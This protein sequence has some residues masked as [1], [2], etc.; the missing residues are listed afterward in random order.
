MMFPTMKSIALLLLTLVM[1]ATGQTEPAEWQNP[2]V[3]RINKEAPRATSVPFPERAQAMAGQP[4][5]WF[6]TLNHQ[7]ERR[8]MVPVSKTSGDYHGP[9]KFHYAG[10]PAARPAD[11]YKPE[12][13]VSSWPSIPVPSN[14]QIHGFGVPLYTNVAYPFKKDPP[15]V[16]STPPGFFTNFPEAQRNPVGSY[17]RSFTLPP[18]WKGRHTFIAFNGVDSAFF[19][20]INGHKV[21][22]SQDSRTTAE[23]DISAFVQPG[24]NIVAVEVYQLSDGSYLEDQDMWRLSGIFRDVYLWSAGKLQVR[25]FWIKAGLSDDY[26]SGTLEIEATLRELSGHSGPATLGFELLDPSGKTIAASS[27]SIS[28]FSKPITLKA[29]AIPNVAAWSAEIPTLYTYLLTLSDAAGKTLAVHTGKTGFRR[30]EVKDGRFLHNGQ[31]ILIK[32]VNRHDHHPVS[33]HYLSEKD[34]RAD[35]LQMKRGNINAVRSSHYPNDPR[36]LE[37]CDEL[38][39]YLV[40][41]A[42][43]ESHGMGYGAQ[44]LAKDPAWG[45]A[46][47]DR[48]KNCLER[49]KNHPC[50]IMWSMGNEAGDGVNFR[51]MAAWIHQRDPSRPVHYERAGLGSHVDIYSAMYAS[52][53][54]CKNYARQQ[55]KKPV[56]EQ[57]P[58]IQ[59]EYSH[60]M[61][62]SSGNLADYWDLIRAEPLLQGGFIW[63]WKDQGLFAFK[64]SSDAVE[65]CSSNDHGSRLLG[66]LSET[67]G[68]YAGGLIVDPSEALDLDAPFTLSAVVRGNY[69]QGG[70]PR[71]SR[72]YPIVSKG[73]TAYSLKIDSTG[74]RLEFFIYTDHWQTVQAD[75]PSDWL[76]EFHDLAGSYD[77]KEIAL[78]IDA[79]KVASKAAS[80]K[81]NHNQHPLAIALN[82]EEPSRRFDGSI[83]RAAIYATAFDPTAPSDAHPA[84]LLE[85]DFLQDATKKKG[86]PYFAYGGDF[87]DH[88]NQGSFCMNGIVQPTLVPSPQFAEVKKVYQD[89]QLSAVDL[90]RPEVKLRLFNERFFKSLDDLKASWKVFQD[91]R[92]IA[93]GNLNFPALAAQ[94]EHLFTI[95]TGVNPKPTSGYLIRI[96][97]DQKDKTAWHPAGFP[98]AWDEFELPWGKRTP[99]E[100]RRGIGIVEFSES[101]DSISIRHQNFSATIDKSSGMLSHWKQ[102]T[103]ELISSPMQLDFWRP[104]T[105]N[106]RGAKF[107]DSLAPWRNAGARSTASSVT[108]SR[109]GPAIE[110]LSQVKI[111]VGSSRATIKWTFHPSGQISVE[112]RFEP[113]GNQLPVIPRIGMRAGINPGNISWKWF[114]KG[115]YENYVDRK[116]GS[117]TAFH[118]G[119]VTSLFHRY[120][121]PQEAGIRSEVRW[122]SFSSPMGGLGIRID[123]SGDSLL[124]IAAIPCSLADLELGNHATDLSKAKE[125][126]L[127]I[128]HRNM[129]LGGT[130]SWGQKPLKKYQIAAKG[131][132]QWSFLLSAELAP[133]PATRGGL[134]PPSLPR[135]LSPGMKP[136]TPPS[137]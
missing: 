62:N 104:M 10:T 24:E 16:M 49:D 66:S 25:D 61:G 20:W 123:A 57:R 114:G 121:D 13:D 38:G 44:S 70:S 36:F 21:G 76:S 69:G 53:D 97:F 40:D 126:T 41:E 19:L 101:E 91:G 89:P 11:F 107:P 115:P 124:Q 63:D 137:N 48:M 103:T 60:A 88:P 39:F 84:P 80:G 37:L 45:P 82:T 50:V 56:A 34:M 117:W 2:A 132:Y 122:A 119:L 134:L 35:L 27:A 5:P 54:A 7:P 22:Y 105:N 75:L 111:P 9:W 67:Q 108:V 118:H 55:S 116:R 26:R 65:D 6:F 90:S 112:A 94:A 33:G 78:Y 12:F 130:N 133:P 3:F 14:W 127:R 71:G 47:L 93:K 23:F 29:P 81:V 83:R 43:I 106:D 52:I 59:C 95:P 8:T 99:P 64:H 1:S 87:N 125:I 98:M 18:A 102:G 110:V 73:D 68:L 74:R 113:K 32:G 72:G 46:H 96:R 30:N 86:Q 136:P 58:M 129:G 92:E 131:S 135:Q 109:K 120:L 100:I 79:K 77:G 4:S 85:F 128:D 51:E 15:R 28:D 31:P 17:R 42:N